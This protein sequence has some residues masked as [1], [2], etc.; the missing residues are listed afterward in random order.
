M[1]VLTRYIHLN[2]LRAKI[3]KTLTDSDQYPYSGHSALMGKIKID[4]QDTDY[5][6]RLFGEKVS[7]ARKAYRTIQKA[8]ILWAFRIPDM[9]FAYCLSLFRI[10]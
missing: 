4:F 8:W 1:L 10:N 5:I 9:C 2:P 6:L 7:A 3:V